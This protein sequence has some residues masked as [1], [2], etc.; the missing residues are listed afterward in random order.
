MDHNNRDRWP[1]EQTYQIPTRDL[2]LFPL[3]E[4]ALILAELAPGDSAYVSHAG[5]YYDLTTICRWPIDSRWQ[6]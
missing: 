1:V 5:E 2:S 6:T 3:R 4:L